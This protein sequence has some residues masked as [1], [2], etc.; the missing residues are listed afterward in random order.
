M[1][2]IINFIWKYQFTFI[3]LL[4]ELIAFLLLAET[5]KFHSANIYSK[6]NRLSGGVYSSIANASEYLKL[7]RINDELS[8]ENAILRSQGL[9]SYKKIRSPHFYINDTLYYQQ[10]KYL[11]A[12]V[13]NNSTNRRNN[14]LILNQGSD[15][16]IF[17]EMGVITKDGLVGIVK[18]VSENYCSVISLLHKSTQISA[19]LKKNNYFGILSWSG[20]D[21]TIAY[22]SDIPNHVK[23]AQ[24]DTIVSRGSSTI[25]PEG[26]LIGTI[27]SFEEQEDDNFYDVFVRLSTD[28]SNINYVHVVK[29]L[30]RK[31][32][33]ELEIKTL[34]DDDD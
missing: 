13:V 30:L 7:S 19:K 9:N 18:D 5:N 20:G 8:E 29:N 26:I 2:N 22:L 11:S 23:L 17:P 1:R 25:F 21:P 27:E 28:F 12:K 15:Q 4:L 34:S 14:Y 24:G 33:L 32:Q 31:E 6:A 3:F 10:Y 16:G